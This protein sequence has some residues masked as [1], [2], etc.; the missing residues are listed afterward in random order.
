MAY[1]QMTKE[2]VEQYG[3]IMNKKYKTE[4]EIKNILSKLQKLFMESKPIKNNNGDDV[5]LNLTESIVFIVQ[6]IFGVYITKDLKGDVELV[7]DVFTIEEFNDKMKNGY[8][9]KDQSQIN[10]GDYTDE[11]LSNFKPEITE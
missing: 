4:K 5:R 7:K 2:V 3:K 11:E 6:P 10:G 8:F 9:E 1:L